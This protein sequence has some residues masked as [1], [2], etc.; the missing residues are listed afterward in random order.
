[1]AKVVL[2]AER[3]TLPHD[4]EDVVYVRAFLGDAQGTRN[5]NATDKVTF[6]V[7][8]PGTI[9]AV[10]NGD[11]KSH[12]PFHASERS[13]YQGTCVAIIRARADAGTITVTASCPGA[14]AGS[15][16]LTAAPAAR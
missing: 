15:V 10:D 12:E 1:V 2:Q 3:T 6:Q 5:P 14:T 16:T 4:F 11:L 8:G 13:A 9:V 7:A